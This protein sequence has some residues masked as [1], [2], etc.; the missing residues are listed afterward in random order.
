M[1][2]LCRGGRYEGRGRAASNG[3]LKSTAKRPLHSPRGAWDGDVYP[4]EERGLGEAVASL[5]QESW[6][7]RRLQRLGI[8][9][10]A[11]LLK[12]STRLL[13]SVGWPLIEQGLARLLLNG[14]S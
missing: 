6:K 9:P 1:M 4:S 8:L 3:R 11:H 13:A 14:G 5:R 2:I 10:E 12:A 7:S